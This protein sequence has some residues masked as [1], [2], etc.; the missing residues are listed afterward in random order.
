MYIFADLCEFARP[1]K[2]FEE[3][4]CYKCNTC[5]W[6]HMRTVSTDVSEEEG[7][8]EDVVILCHSDTDVSEEEGDIKEVVILCHSDRDKWKTICSTCVKTCHS[9]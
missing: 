3:N 7:D 2:S 1:E 8:I 5:Y 4:P 9:G 6:E